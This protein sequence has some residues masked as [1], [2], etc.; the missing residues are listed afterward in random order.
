MVGH[1]IF[2]SSDIK[3]PKFIWSRSPIKCLTLQDQYVN[4]NITQ[5]HTFQNG[6]NYKETKHKK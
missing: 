4:S 2:R 1:F 6:K 5:T 3:N